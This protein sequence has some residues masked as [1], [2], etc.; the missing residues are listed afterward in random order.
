MN[1]KTISS[2]NTA[3]T[4]YDSLF[5]VMIALSNFFTKIFL[6]NLLI[7]MQQGD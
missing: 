6:T 7:L 4:W 5:L 1:H 2:R 3:L